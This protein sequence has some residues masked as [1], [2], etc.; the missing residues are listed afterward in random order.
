MT[1]PPYPA[2]DYVQ[3]CVPYANGNKAPAYSEKNNQEG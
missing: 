1:V 2:I 3:S